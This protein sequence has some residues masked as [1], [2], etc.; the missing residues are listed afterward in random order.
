MNKEI[1]KKLDKDI[2]M[3]YELLSYITEVLGKLEVYRL[4]YGELPYDKEGAISIQESRDNY[5]LHKPMR[6]SLER[7]VNSLIKDE[8]E[9][10]PKGKTK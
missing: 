9:T 6:D 2:K 5:D 3:A 10:K 7:L 8:E 1:E 4:L